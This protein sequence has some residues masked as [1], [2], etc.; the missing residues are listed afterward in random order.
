MLPVLRRGNSDDDPPVTAADAAAAAVAASSETGATTLLDLDVARPV[1]PMLAR[2]LREED[3]ETLDATRYL[4]EL[5]YDGERVLTR[6]RR[7][8]P[9]VYLTRN[10]TPSACRPSR[11]VVL[12]PECRECILDGELIWLDDEDGKPVPICDVG[13]RVVRRTRLML[14]DVQW[15]DGRSVLDLPLER[16]KSLLARCVVE[17]DNVRLVKHERVADRDELMARFDEATLVDGHE[18]LVLKA[19]DER[20]VPDAR[21]WLKLK[22]LYLRDR[23]EEFDLMVYRMLRDRNG[24]WSVLE[25]GYTRHD[26][27][28]RVVVCRVS[29]GLDVA[30]R[31]R[32]RY[33]CTPE[34]ELRLPIACTIVADRVTAQGSLRHPVFQ[35]L[36]DDLPSMLLDSDVDR[37]LVSN[38]DRRRRL[39]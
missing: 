34:G 23:R 19:T 3:L 22:P 33:M 2:S 35:R 36:R 11:G 27:G 38:S 17:T 29:S 14:F 5:K 1:K 31:N 8:S 16:R 21:L 37:R 30:T 4:C 15:L 25:C 32:L 28:D 20:Y 39:H 12:S 13:S 6:V 9:D 7:D 24:V 18:G 10:L 26:T